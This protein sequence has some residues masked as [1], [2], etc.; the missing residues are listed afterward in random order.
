MLY[1]KLEV[2]PRILWNQLR[3]E[4]DD[5]RRVL[6]TLPG[7]IQHNF[8]AVKDPAVQQALDSMVSRYGQYTRVLEIAE[9]RLRDQIDMISSGKSNEMAERSIQESK[10]AILR[11]SESPSY[12]HRGVPSLKYVL[13]VR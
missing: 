8:G 2:E 13:F 11:T 9:A 10:R 7:F 4:L 5:R 1:I 12:P 3:D 6:N